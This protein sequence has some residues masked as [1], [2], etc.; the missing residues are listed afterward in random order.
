MP[1]IRQ[2]LSA[3]F[4]SAAILVG[5]AWAA[6]LVPGAVANEL[7]AGDAKPGLTV[8]VSNI[9]NARG[10]VIVLVM[11]DRDAY[12]QGKYEAAVDFR[13]IPATAGSVRTAF[14]ELTGGPYAVVAFHDENGNRDLDLEGEIP[15]EGYALSGARDAYDEPPFQ[16]AAS[17]TPRQTIHMHYLK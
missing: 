11:D 12:Q 3:I 10:Q 13:E 15:V 9:R 5:G 1:S 7:R 17:Q 16:R 8:T 4:V 6:S 14:P 2:R